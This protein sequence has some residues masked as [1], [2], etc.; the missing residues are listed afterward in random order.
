MKTPTHHIPRLGAGS[1]P[2]APILTEWS[3]AVNLRRDT[4]NKDI[5]RRAG[6]P[7]KVGQSGALPFARF[8]P[9]GDGRAVTLLLG[10]GNSLHYQ[11]ATDGGEAAP[12]DAA[13]APTFLANLPARPILAVTST[14]GVVRL[15]L[16]HQPDH[17]LTYDSELKVTHHGAMPQLPPITLVASEFNTLYGVVPAV[18]LTGG[19][20]GTSGS[21][22]TEADNRRLT[23]ALVGAYDSL[24]Q[25]AASM[26]YCAQPVLARYR[27]L[28]AAGNTIAIGPSVPLSAP[29]GFS[30]TGSI[31]QL[32]ADSLQTLGEGRM[33]MG[34]YRPAVIAP[35][36]L[37]A[38]WD[39]LASRMVVEITREVEPLLR[40]VPAPHGV[41]RD[42]PSGRVTVT[43]KLPG[44]ANGTVTDKPRL[45]R[46]GLAAMSAPMRVAA[47]YDAPFD[48]GIGTPGSIHA[49]SAGDFIQGAD[50][51]ASDGETAETSEAIRRSWGAALQQGEMTV[52][53]DPKTEASQGWSPDC[54]VSS[55]SNAS[56]GSVWRLAFSVRLSTP[57]GEVWVRRDTGGLGN[58]PVSLSPILSF[59]SARANLLN[60]S[61]LSPEGVSY[62]ES[63]PL[64]P[65][66]GRDL[67][68]HASAALEPIT[69]KTRSE[70]YLPRGGALPPRL[71]T[72]MA[73]TYA[74][75][76]L[77][78]RLDRRRVSDGAIHAVTTAPR[79]GSGWD[80]SRLKLLFMGEEGTRVVTLNGAG[81]FHS[82]S[83]VDHR[84]VRSR[85]AVCEATGDAGACLLLLAGDDL[86]SISGQKAVTVKRGVLPSA[87]GT[88]TGG[89]HPAAS[90][91]W[92]GRHREVWLSPGDDT[93][94]YRLTA[95]GELVEARLPG[96]ASPLR[97]ATCQGELL[98]ATDSGVWNLSEEEAVTSLDI[99]LR[100]R[101]RVSA[102]PQWLRLN[103]FA[104]SVAGTATLS[105]DRGT[106]V[107][108]TLLRL[109][110]SG[111]VNAPLTLR[112]A[113]PCR[114]WLET[115]FS[116]SASPDLAILPPEFE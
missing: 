52:L 26:G 109:E 12:S 112:L 17:Y 41:L 97:F 66:A 19:S 13:P 33:E 57:A 94:L 44:F 104:S 96:I 35:A 108:E 22:L 58:P 1:R 71:D 28:D 5:W 105:G 59:P 107:A 20:P 62:E 82:A 67:A 80:F 64:A 100:I 30:A 49:L 84:P 81:M 45:R 24:R 29:G 95:D 53:C 72:G 32:S 10:S 111:A 69:F 87:G 83:P 47:E 93:T 98:A 37:P 68:C 51:P 18:A 21:Q 75:S 56:E 73:E 110:L 78:R 36:S 15:L 3:R 79:S 115:D 4:V 86:V 11:V 76:D 23:D 99:A 61:Y 65:V 91:G 2:A 63:F 16:R 103:I 101:M 77:G 114:R 54:F 102:A 90:L 55:R 8:S 88:G 92:E 6:M 46:L 74:A 116:L 14:P 48:G 70:G 42:T 7:R 60:V 43:S 9:F 39:R 40:G 85:D 31:V 38:P 113:S 106:E 27:L 50:I 89:C 25:R 34:V